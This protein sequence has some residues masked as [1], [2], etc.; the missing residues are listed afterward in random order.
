MLEALSDGMV[1]KG[2]FK[3]DLANCCV[4]AVQHRAK[5]HVQVFLHDMYENK[6]RP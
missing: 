5:E 3:F 2:A 1:V 4:V 6:A